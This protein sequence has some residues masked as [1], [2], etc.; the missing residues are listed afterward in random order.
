EHEMMAVS[1]AGT[2]P[3]GYIS[4]AQATLACERAGKRLCSS[5]EFTTACRGPH[6]TR[7]PYGDQRRASACNDRS[8]K[9]EMHPLMRLFQQY[10]S[11]KSAPESMWQTRWMNDPRLHELSQTVA[12]TGSFPECT[13]GYGVNDMVGNLHEWIADPDG[14]F[15]GGYFKDTVL[16]GEGCS[17]RTTAHNMTYH[18]YSTGFR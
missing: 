11:D 13:N 1:R 9:V 14:T 2:K 8:D 15:A 12:E 18:D 6:H 5:A 3:Q 7:Y 17:Y 4:G 10:S 16:N